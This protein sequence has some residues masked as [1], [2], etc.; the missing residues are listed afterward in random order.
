MNKRP[1]PQRD[2][3]TDFTMSET[4]FLQNLPKTVAMPEEKVMSSKYFEIRKKK[5]FYIWDSETVDGLLFKH[6]KR[7]KQ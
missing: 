7:L 5:T 2:M 3:Q 1:L 6:N 4:I